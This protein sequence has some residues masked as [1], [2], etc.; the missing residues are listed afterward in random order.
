MRVVMARHDALIEAAVADH[1]GVVVRD[2]GEG[3]SRFGVFSQATAAV[4]A[5]CAM[6]IALCEESWPLPR[7]LRVRIALH[8]GEA[9]VRDGDYYGSD[10]NRCARLRA[11]AVGGQ[12]LLSGTTA[13]LARALIPRDAALADL[14]MYQL[15]DLAEPEHV[16]QLLHAR[17]PAEFPPLSSSSSLRLLPNDATPLFARTT[18]LRNLEEALRV[19]EVRL[20]T[21]VGA[22]GIGKT[23]LAVALAKQLAPSFANGVWFVDL[24]ATRDPTL[25]SHTI[26]RALG[27]HVAGSRTALEQV[28]D[29]LRSCH[30]VLVLDNFEQVLE[31]APDVSRLLNECP[32]VKVLATSREPLRLRWERV[33]PVRPLA[34]PNRNE[35]DLQ[36]LAQVPAIQ[37]FIQ[38]ARS[39]DPE[40][41]LTNDN[42]SALVELCARLDGLPLA[43]ELAAA[44]VRAFTPTMLVSMLHRELDA[45]HGT[46]DAPTRQQS[47]R[48][49]VEWSYDL[50]KSHEQRLFRRIAVF[51]GGC[52]LESARAISRDPDEP[53]VLRGLEALVDKSLLQRERDADG[54]TRFRMLE[55]VRGIALDKLQNS[56]DDEAGHV[57]QRHAEHFLDLAR[58]A[59]QE[60]WGEEAGAC[61]DR[62]EREHDNLRQALSW[63]IASQRLDLAQAMVSALEPLWFVRRH[64]SEGHRW[65]EAALGPA[66]DAT[67]PAQHYPDRAT[68][69]ALLASAKGVLG[70][71]RAAHQLALEAEAEAR[72]LGDPQQLSWVLWLTAEV[73]RALG[74]VEHAAA[75]LE[76]AVELRRATGMRLL[77]GVM[78]GLLGRVR[79]DQG[80][81]RE[82]QAL[83]L[84]AFQILQGARSPRALQRVQQVLGMIALI[85]GDVPEARRLLEG[86]VANG[87]ALGDGWG[88]LGCLTYLAMTL[89]T[90]GEFHRA[91]LLLEE[92]IELSRGE[93]DPLNACR[94]LG[95]FARLAAA[96]GQPERA[97]RLAGAA[98][99]LQSSASLVMPDSLNRYVQTW[100]SQA[101]AALGSRASEVWASGQRLSVEEATAYASSPDEPG[102][103]SSPLSRR[104]REVAALLAHGLSNRE[105]AQQLVISE[106]TAEAHV[107]HILTKLGLTTR[108]QIALWASEREAAIGGIT[109]AGGARQS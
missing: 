106:R 32:D 49:T 94:Y 46:V 87:R 75:C 42:A 65:L 78:L 62:L 17:L 59:Y 82:G 3:D 40:F 30:A 81:P 13:A 38:R 84:Q 11:L 8:T 26:A 43:L 64:M 36:T 23:R 9:D 98:F 66:H 93:P 7:P 54:R 53:D 89:V 19:P 48:A 77:E 31:A 69:L 63:S 35:S 61:L 15:K 14:G 97:V 21:L 83:S 85:G 52:T 10:V 5:A 71:A 74:D 109:D 108:L 92:S 90:E 67:R 51:S 29:Y 105:I 45:L 4:A 96:Q 95:G 16:Y 12:V 39:A 18:E 57:R 50:L 56:P 34:V 86:A 72:R 20:L 24:S 28:Q 76:E 44:H 41:A 79:F 73:A 104:E 27:L 101:R 68:T 80:R 33:A 58:S 47:L 102:P 107:A 70:D 25:V 37:F 60:S 2:R 22:G 6:Q 88:L 103:E 99:A 55:T 91:R 1:D 100:L